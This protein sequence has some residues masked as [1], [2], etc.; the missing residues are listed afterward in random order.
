MQSTAAC[1]VKMADSEDNVDRVAEMNAFALLRA[2]S[3]LLQY[4]RLEH[5]P[6]RNSSSEISSISQISNASMDTSIRAIL[7]GNR[8]DLQI[9]EFARFPHYAALVRQRAVSPV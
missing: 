5:T 4:E 2:L 1:L 8:L 3:A 7:P 9:R 6:S